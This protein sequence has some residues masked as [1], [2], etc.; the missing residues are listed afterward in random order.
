MIKTFLSGKYS[1][2]FD[3]TPINGNPAAETT[4][5]DEEQIR[6]RWWYPNIKEGDVILDIGAGFGSYMLPALAVGALFVLGFSPEHDYNR[7]VE[8]LKLNGW[9]C[10]DKKRLRCIVSQ[11]GIYSKDG[12]LDTVSQQFENHKWDDKPTI[13]RVTTLD[14]Y[15][16]VLRQDM[17][18]H[19]CVDRIDI[20]K[21]DV[22]GAE[23]EALKGAINTLKRYRPKLLIENHVFKN[24]KID[25][26]ITQW[27]EEQD[28]GYHKIG[29]MSYGP[30]S[31]SYYER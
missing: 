19:D 18:C 21:L 31:H 5:Y 8:N 29:P 2:V 3:P 28:L 14:A 17:K 6:I 25:D 27:F 23:L 24:L 12:F 11:V 22:E 26:Q 9:H 30:I 1:F 7:L 16:D 4:F 13:I 20:M 10:N 15:L